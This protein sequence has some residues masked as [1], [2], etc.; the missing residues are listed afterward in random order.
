MSWLIAPLA[1]GGIVAF[2]LVLI[3]MHARQRAKHET[4]PDLD[5]HERLFHE[6]RYR[7]R[8][9]TSSM[10]MG[11]GALVAVGDQ[12]FS[13][14][15]APGWFAVY[16]LVVLLVTFWIVILAIGDMAQTKVHTRAS[17]ARIRRKQR[18]LQNELAK[19][20]QEF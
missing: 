9:Q 19:H 8:M 16:W 14:E 18:E 7:R 3:R 1:G 2:G 20:R 12:L 5:E 4:D 11:V 15:E 6:R 13:W 17:M 10:L